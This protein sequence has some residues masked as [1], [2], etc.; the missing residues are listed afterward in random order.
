MAYRRFSLSEP[1]LEVQPQGLFEVGQPYTSFKICTVDGR[2]DA[3]R[4]GRGEYR[5]QT[6]SFLT[7]LTL[8]DSSRRRAHQRCS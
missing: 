6:T 4:P 1:L 2:H 7:E 3:C 8:S 5:F